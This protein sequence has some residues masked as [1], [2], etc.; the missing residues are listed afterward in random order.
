MQK[1]KQWT[2]SDFYQDHLIMIAQAIP[3]KMMLTCLDFDEI[4]VVLQG[5]TPEIEYLLAFLS[6][7]EQ[8]KLFQSM[9]LI[10]LQSSSV[11]Y[12]KKKL[13]N[14]MIKGKL[15]GIFFSF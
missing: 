5:Q 6:S 15:E 13:V 12:K 3:T 8:S 4:D 9:N 2:Q 7:L 1:I 10:D 14:F 11:L